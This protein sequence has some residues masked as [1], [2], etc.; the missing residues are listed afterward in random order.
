MIKQINLSSPDEYIQEIISTFENGGVAIPLP[1]GSDEIDVSKFDGVFQEDDRFIIKTSGSTGDSKGVVLGYNALFS[2]AKSLIEIHGFKKGDVH[3]SCL[4]LNH[5]NA[6]CMSVIA[7]HV[8][9]CKLAYCDSKNMTKYFEFIKKVNGRT[10]TI[11]PALI[12]KLVEEKP[13]FPECLEYLITAAAPLS[14]DLAK[15]FYDLYGDR[16]VQGYGLSESVNF[17]FVTPRLK[18]QDFV[19][20]YINH[21]PPVGLPLSDTDFKLSDQGEVLIKGGSLFSRYQN[22]PKKTEE[23]FEIIDGEKWLKTGDIGYIRG[24]Y[25]VLKGRIKEIINF[26]GLTLSPNV[27]EDTWN[28]SGVSAYAFP[29]LSAVFD[30]EIGMA[31]T[32]DNYKKVKPIPAA[33]FIGSDNFTE[34]GKPQRLKMGKNMRG[35]NFSTD[36]YFKMIN[37]AVLTAECF[38]METGKTDKAKAVIASANRCIADYKIHY[39]GAEYK[40]DIFSWIWQNYNF[41]I[42]GKKEGEHYILE[43]PEGWESLMNNLMGIYPKCVA[44]IIDAI[45]PGGKILELGSGVGNL[46]KY[47]QEK[48][49]VI[50]SDLSIQYVKSFNTYQNEVLRINF[51]EPIVIPEGVTTVVSCNALHCAKDK[52]VTLRNIYDGLK[53]GGKLILGEGEKT[54]NPGKI[55][56]FDFVF[57]LFDGWFGNSGFLEEKEWIDIFYHAGFKKIEVSRIRSGNSSL[58]VVICGTK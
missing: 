28:E 17:S 37:L 1:L 25:L 38:V 55:W 31:C 49:E 53:P 39:R 21:T 42:E 10:A 47:I 4:P 32:L 11:V 45:N 6:L 41:I 29:V 7:T 14:K 13:E 5:V 15:K 12:H 23:A 27:I 58:G 52:L 40:E 51:D 33:I 24:S 20:E 18:G 8:A 2:N 35:F 43:K 30:N 26:G 54:P 46:T 19:N 36:L 56:A 34:T 16:L 57:Q 44:E 50:S 3:V 22:E 9:G 48:Y